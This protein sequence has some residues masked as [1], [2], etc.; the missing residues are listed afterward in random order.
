MRKNG[1]RYSDELKNAAVTEYLTTDITIEACQVKYGFSGR[2]TLR[3][4]IRKYGI[5]KDAKNVSYIP[6]AMTDSKDKSVNE[7]MLEARIKELETALEMEKLRTEALDT[8]INIAEEKLK[9]SIRKKP[10]AKQ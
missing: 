10:G 5:E 3:N 9:I 7:S 1:N 2:G 4:W 8:M 6:K